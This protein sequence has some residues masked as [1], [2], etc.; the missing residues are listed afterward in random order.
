VSRDS[1]ERI[2][3][4]EVEFAGAWHFLERS[5]WLA[6]CDVDVRK[7]LR[8]IAALVTFAAGDYLYR[9]GDVPNGVFG[10]VSGAIDSLIPR[11]DGEEI[12]VH[13]AG[14][15]FWIG[16]L[17]LFSKQRR[18][19]SLRAA[20]PLA[21]IHL[22]QKELQE[23]THRQPALIGDFYRLSHT[24]MAMTLSLLGNL[25]VSG[26]E[27]RVA[28]RLLIQHPVLADE[29]GWIPLGQEALAEL[30]ALSTQSVR[31]ALRQLESQGLLELGY[32]RIRILDER[33]L[34]GLCGYTLRL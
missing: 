9:A 10:L 6:S 26:A 18:L 14:G 17:A 8:S 5:G 13:R 12:V 27:N 16:D 29:D 1:G 30:V 7:S 21:V 28:L 24:N 11:L 23:I 22:P 2:P 3:P 33:K 31:R 19:L 25:A 34:S 32:R 20:T 15:G 4:V